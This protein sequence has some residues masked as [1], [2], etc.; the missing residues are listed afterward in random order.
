VNKLLEACA[1][2]SLGVMWGCSS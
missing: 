2:T 1:W